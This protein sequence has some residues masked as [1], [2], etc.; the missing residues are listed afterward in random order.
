MVVYLDNASTTK[1]SEAA[2]AASLDALTIG[3]GN[4]SSA[5]T[6]GQ[7]AERVVKRAR[8]AVA[9]VICAEPQ[10]IVFTGSGT[11]ANNLSVAAAFATAARASGGA[12]F[13]TAMEHPA[14]RAPVARASELGAA[15]YI[16]PAGPCGAVD[17]EAAEDALIRA[18]ESGGVKRALISVMHVNNETGVIQPVAEM[19][20][21]KDRLAARFDAEII[22]HTDAVQ[23]YGKLPIDVSSGDGFGGFAGVDL[24]S[25]SAHKIHGPK[26]VG[27][28]YARRP[29]KLSPQALGGGQEGGKRSGTENVPGIAGFGAAASEAAAAGGAEAAGREANV[30]DGWQKAAVRVKALR[31][32]LLR[33]IMESIDDVRISSPEEASADGEPGKCS[34]YILNVSFIGT[35][36]E[37]IL[38]D[39]ERSGVFVSTGAA[40]S[41]IGKGPGR[42]S[43]ALTAAG[44]T[45]AEAEAAVRFS[46]SRCNTEEEID[47]AIERVA[48]AV[49]RFRRVGSFR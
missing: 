29:G 43:P 46:L 20:R 39:L 9:D 13:T 49:T 10:S 3:Y 36:G 24:L 4:P 14:V 12:V 1:P 38:H 21:V 31:E 19:A 32:R 37:V 18:L 6:M 30:A 23:S 16:L 47:C 34:P 48:E 2:I 26:G 25:V 42:V 44:L 7:D 41:N 15:P 11:E 17:T 8:L 28:L 27:A 45:A 33:G 40:C 35:R 22:F 5:H